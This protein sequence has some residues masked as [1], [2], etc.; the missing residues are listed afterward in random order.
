MA[1]LEKPT[2]EEQIKFWLKVGL[3]HID[4]PQTQVSNSCEAM[5]LDTPLN[6]WYLP[7]GFEPDNQKRLIT[8]K[9]VP[10]LDLNNLFKCAVP[11]LVALDGSSQG[12][13]DFRIYPGGISVI[14]TLMD[15]AG[16][17]E[18][19]YFYKGHDPTLALFWAIWEIGGIR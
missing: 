8:F 14:L 1:N 15:E 12:E 2:E 17:N 6:G 19:D 11:K 7:M 18:E 13:I 5:C 16:F 10:L 3:I 9:A 4:R